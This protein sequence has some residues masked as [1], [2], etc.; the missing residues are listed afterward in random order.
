MFEKT[1]SL[2]P[3]ETANDVEND[4][5]TDI[6]MRLRYH[7]YNRHQLLEKLPFS[8]AILR[9][10]LPLSSYICWL[11]VLWSIHHAVEKQC[12]NHLAPVVRAIWQDD[13]VKTP[14]LEQDLAYFNQVDIYTLFSPLVQQ[15]TTDFVHYIHEMGS[16]NP[17]VLLGILYVLEGSTLGARALLPYLQAAYSL[18]EDGVGY[19]HAYGEQTK[20]H[21]EDFKT[22][23][24]AIVRETEAQNQ[25][26][27][28]AQKTYHYINVLLNLL[29]NS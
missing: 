1:T 14:L 18:E 10:S 29:W 12:S 5:F 13:M 8:Q 7:T 3:P 25:V 19:Y 28:G 15:T 6:M 11:K 20:N 26:I 16:Q 27:Q 23:M 9:K 21:W 4:G 17:L 2:L 22:G 24:N